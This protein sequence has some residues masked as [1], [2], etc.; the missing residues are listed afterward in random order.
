MADAI[1]SKGTCKKKEILTTMITLMKAAGWNDISS[2]PATDFFIMHS[3]GESGDKD[4]FIQF[5]HG[6][7]SNT[8]PIDTTDY[9]AAS[10][11]LISEYTPGAQGVAGTFERPSES[12]RNFYVA[13]TTTLI[14]SEVMMTYYY[15]VNK[16][17]IIFIIETPES[18]SFAPATHYFGLPTSFVSEPKSR[19]LI[20]ASSTYAVTANNVYVTNAAGELPSDTASS[21]RTVYSAMPPKSPNSSGKHT[22]VEIYYGNTTEGIRGKIDGLY[23]VPAGGI[24]NGDTLTVGTKQFRAVVNGVASSNSFPSTTLIFQIQ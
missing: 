2:N 5:R 15:H 7:T 21:G 19:G 14:N 11:R 8:N 10:F 17:R 18:L 20:A 24:N 22:P 16:N 6:S 13:P 3:K 12:W 9:N 4:L 23:V 1:F